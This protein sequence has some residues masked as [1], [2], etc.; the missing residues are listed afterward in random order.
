[1]DEMSDIM[2]WEALKSGRL[3]GVRCI[4]ERDAV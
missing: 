1:M 2:K 4:M 3:V